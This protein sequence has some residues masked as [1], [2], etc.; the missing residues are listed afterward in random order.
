M[1]G[2]DARAEL[3]TLQKQLKEQLKACGD[4]LRADCGTPEGLAALRKAL[5]RMDRAAFGA[6]S[7][8]Q[9]LQR[10]EDVLARVTDQFEQRFR[11][12]EAAFLRGF[13]E[14]GRIAREMAYG[15]RLGC[16]ELKLDRRRCYASI[17]YDGLPVFKDRPVA[18]S[19]DLVRLVEDSEAQMRADPLDPDAV[20]SVIHDA[21][22]YLLA[23]QRG[24]Q[25]TDRVSLE[26]LI[27]EF[28][29]AE[30][31][32]RLG[33][34]RASAA[35]AFYREEWRIRYALDRYFWEGTSARR[36]RL[37]TGSQM[38]TKAHGVLL[39]GLSP[40]HELSMYCYAARATERA[41]T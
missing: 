13:R 7:L 30:Y 31:R 24:Q 9:T 29:V 32:F 25:A 12:A 36:L 15:W 3:E 18:S 2:D 19:D 20:A 14:S 33:S 6:G 28:R 41:G 17:L 35:D 11:T 5:G 10:I 21:F 34:R 22:D 16:F 4:L 1:T 37:V 26:K 38:E 23:L 8:G 40:S 39:G 27:A